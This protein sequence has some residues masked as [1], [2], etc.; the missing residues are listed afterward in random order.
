L[1]SIVSV[2]CTGTGRLVTPVAD[3]SVAPIPPPFNT[4][5]YPNKIQF[6]NVAG[7]VLWSGAA[8]GII[9]GVTQINVQL[10]AALPGKTPLNAVPMTL[11][12]D[13]VYSPAVSIS[14]KQ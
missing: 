7:T 11:E 9:Q 6:A 2:Y 4:T 1:G 13:G 14:V 10:P 12:V 3:G 8:P 5:D